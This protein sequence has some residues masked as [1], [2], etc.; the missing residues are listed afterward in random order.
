MDEVGTPWCVTIDSDTLA[1]QTVTV[2][3]RDSMVQERVPM[4]QLRQHL[5]GRME[6]WR[7]PD[8]A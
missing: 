1:D 8:A 7:H 4:D 5:E 2:R 3:D 6:A